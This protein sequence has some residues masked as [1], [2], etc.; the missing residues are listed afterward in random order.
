MRAR[1]VAAVA[2]ATM[3]TAL[4]V[5]LPTTAGAATDTTAPTITSMTVATP[6]VTAGSPIA[7]RFT[8]V[9]DVA[10]SNVSARFVGPGGFNINLLAADGNWPWVSRIGGPVAGVVPQGAPAGT[11]TL[12]DLQ[13][14]DTSGNYTD[15]VPGGGIS[16]PGGDPVPLDLASV[17]LTVKQPRTADVTAPTLSVF[18]MRSDRDRRQG[19]FVSWAFA[20][21]DA[22][23]IAEVKVFLRKPNGS[24]VET[25]RGGGILTSG[26]ISFWIPTDEQIGTWTVTGVQLTDTSGNVRSY[27]SAGKGLQTGQPTH[28]GPAFDAKTFKVSAG[29]VRPDGIRVFDERPDPVVRTAGPSVPVAL[30]STAALT[31]TVTFLGRG[32]PYPVLALFKNVGGTRTFVRLVTGG[33][34]GAYSTRVPVTGTALYQLWFLGSDRS[35]ALVPQL[36]GKPVRVSA[37]V[38]QTLTVAKTS[39]AVPAGGSGVLSVTLSPHRAGATVVLRRWTGSTWAAVRTVTT[40]ADGAAFATVSRPATTAS[41]RW[42][43]A[44]DGTGLAATSATVTVTR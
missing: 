27:N 42:T 5:A 15:Y 12:W 9:D 3:T 2:A 16:V 31:G 43:T 20:A 4:A 35:V 26:R 17:T 18:D 23:T 19:E 11:Y 41:Y 34:T 36:M 30:G 44:Y 25:H 8:A 21:A 39:V 40:R 24:T 22:T 28:T 32:V 37:G 6:V 13:V 7:L 1:L 14:T 10:V 29:T 38:K 33:A